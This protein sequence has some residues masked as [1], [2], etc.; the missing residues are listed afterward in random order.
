MP[1]PQFVTQGKPDTGVAVKTSH[2]AL[3]PRLVAEVDRESDL[4][5]STG[6]VASELH[7]DDDDMPTGATTELLFSER[8]GIAAVLYDHPN[9]GRLHR[10][11]LLFI[12]RRRFEYV[13]KTSAVAAS[14]NV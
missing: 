4:T 8:K 11:G 12:C 14:R 10:M 2:D 6:Y 3:E 1:S 7:A 5:A 9:I 13:E